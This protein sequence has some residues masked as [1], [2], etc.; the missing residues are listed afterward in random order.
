MKKI[1]CLLLAMLCAISM[2]SCKDSA[3]ESSQSQ[4]EPQEIMIQP[5]TVDLFD[6]ENRVEGLNPNEESTVTDSAGNVLSDS[7]WLLNS[8]FSKSYVASLGIGT[9]TYQ[10]RSESKYGT[11]TLIVADSKA[12]NYVWDFEMKKNSAGETILYKDDEVLFPLLN[13]EQDSFQ[14]EYEIAYQLYASG[15][16]E[17]PIDTV[18]TE[19]GYTIEETLTGSYRWTAT[20]TKV[21]KEPYIFSQ[22]FRMESFDEYVARKQGEFLYAYTTDYTAGKYLQAVGGKYE[23]DTKFDVTMV[24]KNNAS[25][26]VFYKYQISNEM[27]QIALKEGRTHLTYTL[28]LDAPMNKTGLWVTNEWSGLQVGFSEKSFAN[29]DTWMWNE[30]KCTNFKAVKAGSVYTV[31]LDLAEQFFN[32]GKNLEF[33][34]VYDQANYDGQEPDSNGIYDAARG[35]LQ[36]VFAKEDA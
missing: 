30:D 9:Y 26:Q 15:E 31:S 21:G 3:T 33:W 12:P 2:V 34:I 5:I 23:I 29:T 13:K 11:I 1:S 20:A 8:K 6:P 36:C 17:T 10:Y 35:S 25:H 22:V 4:I 24:N 16:Q 27:V 7:Q 19:D 18:L 32:T 28:T 14:S